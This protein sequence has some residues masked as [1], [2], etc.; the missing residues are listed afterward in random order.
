MAKDKLPFSTKAREFP[1]ERAK[2]TYEALVAAGA[3]VFAELGFDATQTPEIAARAGVSVG[4]FYRYFADKREIFLEIVRRSLTQA[5]KEVLSKLTPDRFVGKEK[6]ATIELALELLLD[7][8]TRDPAMQ[9]VVLEM[10]MRDEQVAAARRA[11]DDIS[12]QRIAAL[13]SAICPVED[14][15]D[16]EATAF[17]IQTAAAESAITIS[18]MRGKPPVDR[19]RSMAALT[20]LVYRALFGIER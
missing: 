13:I 3:V 19:E 8:V 9:R 10:S 2:K 4:T 18:G 7:N 17:I 6:R 5:H 1:Q 15:P 14:V 12:H 16:P 20:E 11:F